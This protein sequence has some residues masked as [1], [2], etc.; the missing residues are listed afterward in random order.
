MRGSVP[1]A[2]PLPDRSQA[3]AKEAPAFFG[4]SA[5]TAVRGTVPL[6][7]PAG[8][9]DRRGYADEI[10]PLE[11]AFHAA[12]VLSRGQHFA[13]FPCE[14]DDL[15]ALFPVQVHMGRFSRCLLLLREYSFSLLRRQ[16]LGPYSK[17]QPLSL[18]ALAARSLCRRTLDSAGSVVP[19]SELSIASFRVRRPP[20]PRPSPNSSGGSRPSKA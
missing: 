8:L 13:A 11:D 10:V 16:F 12:D 19:R 4:T 20:T 9:A 18:A 2:V 1:R 14:D 17:P 5:L 3:E 7:V 15:E 6:V